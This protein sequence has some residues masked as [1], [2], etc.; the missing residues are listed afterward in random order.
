MIKDKVFTLL[1]TKYSAAL[2]W[3]LRVISCIVDNMGVLF[4]LLLALCGGMSAL[5]VMKRF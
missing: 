2:S 5:I 1:S 3:T 4:N